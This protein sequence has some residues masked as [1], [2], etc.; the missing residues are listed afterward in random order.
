MLEAKWLSKKV[1]AGAIAKLQKQVRQLV[2]STGCKPGSLR[3][4]D[5]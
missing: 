1:D 5:G 2:M 3:K 4:L